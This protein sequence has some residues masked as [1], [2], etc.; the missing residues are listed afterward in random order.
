MAKFPRRNGSVSKTRTA[1]IVAA[2]VVLGV[3]AISIKP[4]WLHTSDKSTQ[5][6][7]GRS[8]RATDSSSASS[9]SSF[10]RQSAP[11]A[12]V[13]H[14]VGDDVLV[15]YLYD[16]RDPVWVEN[17]KF[18]LQWGVNYND[19]CSYVIVVNEAM[20]AAKVGLQSTISAGVLPT[21][22]IAQ[23]AKDLLALGSVSCRRT[24]QTLPLC[25]PMPSTCQLIQPTVRQE[26]ACSVRL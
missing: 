6:P 3:L 14:S 16:N 4:D 18:F 23:L 21:W 22:P 20:Y 8:L 9:T 1:A 13:S 7:E 17:F 5:R 10:F 15:L 11:Q 19:G 12:P 26:W 25:H 2:C 24:Y